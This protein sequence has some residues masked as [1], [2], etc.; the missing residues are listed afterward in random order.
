MLISASELTEIKVLNG[1]GDIDGG[2]R[3]ANREESYHGAFRA[4]SFVQ[5]TLTLELT[6][7]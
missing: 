3:F 6:F 2:W 4:A 7:R 1:W 5:E